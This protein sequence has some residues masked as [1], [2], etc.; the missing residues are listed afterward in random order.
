[1]NMKD[2]AFYRYI[3]RHGLGYRILKDNEH[4]GWYDRIE[5]ALYDRDRLE[6]VDWDI[7]TWTELP[8]T[9][10]PYEHMNLPPYE[11][12]K[13]TYIT[14]I[15]E[16]WRV[17]KRIDGKMSYFGSYDTFEEAEKRRNE[18]IIKGVL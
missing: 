13:S 11:E 17:Q 12:S 14:H 10:N 2:K 5:D 9:P 15:P 7:Q 18:L 3:Y 4:F 16:K 8:E 1:M 6:Q